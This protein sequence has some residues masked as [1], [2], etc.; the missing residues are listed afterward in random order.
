VLAAHDGDR[1]TTVADTDDVRLHTFRIGHTLP[2]GA[3]VGSVV[4]DGR[5]VD[6]YDAV[7]TNRGVEVS[8]EAAPG[9]RHTLVVTA[10]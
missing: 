8:V 3:T 6:D 5:P 10:G 4:L 7:E 9:R 2:R 1:Y